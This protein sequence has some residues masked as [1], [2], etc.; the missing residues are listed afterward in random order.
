MFSFLSCFFF[1]NLPQQHA[2]RLALR[3]AEAVHGNKYDVIRLRYDHNNN[4]DDDDDDD[5]DDNVSGKVQ[6]LQ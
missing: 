1:S 2:L 3:I 4:N 5:E 6:A